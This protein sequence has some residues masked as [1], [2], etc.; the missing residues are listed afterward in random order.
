VRGIEGQ[1]PITTWLKKVQFKIFHTYTTPTRII[2]EP[3]FQVEETG[4]GGF[5][6]EIK[7]F[8]IPEV[9][10]RQQDRQHYLQL[11]PYGT[12][13]EIQKQIEAKLVRAEYLEIIEFNEPTEALWDILT[14]EAQFQKPAKRPTG[15]GKAKAV[16]KKEE[17]EGSVELPEHSSANSPYSKD[18]ERANLL[19]IR[20]AIAKADALMAIE[21]KRLEETKAKLAAIRALPESS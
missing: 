18:L 8:F 4:W 1:P 21:D 12:E 11:E 19:Q 6:V 15:K 20:R 17:G 7:L 16:L 3:P 5:N 2:E 9:N 13:A 10:A 14:D